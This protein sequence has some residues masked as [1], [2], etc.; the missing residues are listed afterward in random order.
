M[1][2]VV[3]LDTHV[4]LWLYEGLLQY[5]PQ[6]VQQRLNRDDLAISPLVAIELTYLHEIGRVKPMASQVVEELAERVELAVSDISTVALCLAA[7][8]LNWTRDPFDRLLA[9]HATATQLPL[10]TKDATIRQYLPL[11]WWAE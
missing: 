1:A 4:V 3:L 11:A 9:A 2:S 5:I 10:V 7:A 8:E 6:P